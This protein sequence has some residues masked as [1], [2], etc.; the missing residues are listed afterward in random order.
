M[1]NRVAILLS[2]ITALEDCFDSPPSGVAEQRRQ[3]DLIRYATVPS[4]L[5]ALIPPQRAQRNRGTTAAVV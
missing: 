3:K 5:P 4:L 1:G 2:P